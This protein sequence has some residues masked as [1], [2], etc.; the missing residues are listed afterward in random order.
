MKVICFCTKQRFPKFKTCD[1][2]PCCQ[3]C[4]RSISKDFTK[5]EMSKISLN[6]TVY[7]FSADHSAIQKEYILNS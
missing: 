7:E 1:N 4:L 3:F 6:G 2:V 5:D